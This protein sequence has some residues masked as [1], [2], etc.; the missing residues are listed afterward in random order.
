M[1]LNKLSFNMQKTGFIGQNGLTGKQKDERPGEG[2]GAW[3]G[4][5]SWEPEAQPRA[6]VRRTAP[7][8]NLC[9]LRK[10][11]WRGSAELVSRCGL[12]PETWPRLMLIT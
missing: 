2:E 3:L 6:A 5:L 12:D 1:F 11:S 9:F 10:E 8:F 4:R 7:P